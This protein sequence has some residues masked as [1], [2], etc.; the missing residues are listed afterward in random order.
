MRLTSA[1]DED[2]WLA[3]HCGHAVP[4][5]RA[6]SIQQTEVWVGPITGLDVVAKI[7]DSIHVRNQTVIILAMEAVCTSE[8]SVYFNETTWHYITVGYHPDHLICNQSL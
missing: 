2:E 5:K 8:M 7:K 1:L 3:S 6:P 4:R